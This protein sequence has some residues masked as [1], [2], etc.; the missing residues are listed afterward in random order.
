M[1]TSL[2]IQMPPEY[3]G[4]HRQYPWIKACG[5]G[6][7]DGSTRLCAKDRQK[8][9][10]YRRRSQRAQCGFYL[11]L[12]GHR[13]LFLRSGRS[14]EDALRHSELPSSRNV[15]RTISSYTGNRVEVRLETAVE[16]GGKRMPVE[17][18]RREYDAVYITGGAMPIK[19]WD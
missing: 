16:G 10:G 1:R 13:T 6:W 17:E 19:D 9:C 5:C 3:A 4:Q 14:W 7:Q 12:M 18:L 15:F 2:R 8:D 11:Q